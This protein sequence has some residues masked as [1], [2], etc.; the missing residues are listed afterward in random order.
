MNSQRL[1]RSKKSGMKCLFKSF[2][3]H[4]GVYALKAYN[5]EIYKNT[6]IF[7]FSTNGLFVFYFMIFYH[8]KDYKIY[9]FSD[10]VSDSV[11]DYISYFTSAAKYPSN[12][13]LT[14][15]SIICKLLSIF[16]KL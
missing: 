16:T 13:D 11:C 8:L 4:K 3:V 14:S 10:E 12:Q 1:F 6:F 2:L 5:D 7:F 15:E 9:Y